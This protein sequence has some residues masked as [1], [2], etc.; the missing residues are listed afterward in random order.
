MC[1]FLAICSKRFFVV[2][3]VWLSFGW[4]WGF[5]KRILFKLNKSG[6][7]YRYQMTYRDDF[8]VKNDF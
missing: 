5:D 6:S 1:L 8:V 3:E 2:V 7:F 4:V